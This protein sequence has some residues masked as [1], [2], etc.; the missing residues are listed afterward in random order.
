[1]K[2]STVLSHEADAINP[3]FGINL[4]FLEKSQEFQT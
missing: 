3:R 2:T 1:M 4:I